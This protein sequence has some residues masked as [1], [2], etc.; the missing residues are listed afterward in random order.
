MRRDDLMGFI[1]D[2]TMYAAILGMFSFC[3]FGWA[4]ERP[5]ASW[6]MWIGLASGVAFLVCLVGV[7]LSIRNWDE[8]SALSETK[9]YAAYLI[10]VVIEFCLAG[11]GAFFLLRRKKGDYVAPWI[12]FIVGIHFIALVGVFHDPALYL[13]AGLLTVVAISSVFIARRLDVAS[14]AVA[15]IGSGSVLLG[16][17]LL[18]LVRYMLV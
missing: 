2:Y 8:P 7:Y 18:G 15:G 12:T 10:T 14:S 16:F 9:A 6:R 11:A 4:Q 3:W 1:R 5:R 17:A 13:L